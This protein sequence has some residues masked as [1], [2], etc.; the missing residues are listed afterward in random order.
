MINT[1]SESPPITMQECY[2]SCGK[3]ISRIF[4]LNKSM[5]VY[6]CTGT[7][8]HWYICSGLNSGDAASKKAQVTE[9]FVK[10]SR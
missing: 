5:G 3:T 9:S 2:E 10:D 7:F 4:L 1:T 8:C 6:D